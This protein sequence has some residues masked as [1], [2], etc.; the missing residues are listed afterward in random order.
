MV[1]VTHELEALRD[2]VTRVVCMESGRIDFDGTP[3]EYASHLAAHDIGS[4][5]HHDPSHDGRPAEPD[6]GARPAGPEPDAA[7]RG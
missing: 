6:A 4:S 3:T 5:H 1:V 7:P 2:V